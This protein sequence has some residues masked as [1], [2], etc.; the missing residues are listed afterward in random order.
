MTAL[1][2]VRD[3]S[4]VL[5]RRR[6]VDGVSFSLMPGEVVG[7]LGANGAGKTTL[8][9]AILGLVGHDGR[10]LFRGEDRGAF[11]PRFWAQRVALLAQGNPVSWPLSVETV[12]A[13]GRLPHRGAWQAETEADRA[14]VRR[15][16]RDADI[17]DLAERNVL[18]LSAGER[19]RVLFA[20]ALAV[21]AVVLLADEP[22]AALDPYHQL[23]LMELIRAYAAAGRAVAVVMHDLALA[24]RYC[25]RL[26]VMKSGRV[27]V[28][29]PPAEAL[30]DRWLDAA[31]S[32]RGWHHDHDGTPIVLPWSRTA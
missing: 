26:I 12:V 22:T 19:A 4:V 7:L 17:T 24:A 31:F 15:A 25:D 10:V 30:Q 21:E 1:L 8:L 2:D 20:R 29:G 14:A 23:Q 28:A 27:L 32:V 6:V 9:R 3:I 16:L 11:A 18:S 5:D 13:L